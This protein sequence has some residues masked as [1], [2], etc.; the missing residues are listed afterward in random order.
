MHEELLKTL[1]AVADVMLVS[2]LRDKRIGFPSNQDIRVFIPDIHLISNTRSRFFSK[3]ATDPRELQLL[4][5]IVTQLNAFKQRASQQQKQVVVYQL[6]DC[7]DLWREIDPDVPPNSPQFRD[8]MQKIRD[9]NASLVRALRDENLATRF[10][11]GNHDIDLCYWRDGFMAWERGFFIENKIAVL[12]GDVFDMVERFPDWLQKLAVYFFSPK[13]SDYDIG[14]DIRP[15]TTKLR[16]RDYKNYLQYQ[17]PTKIGELVDCQKDIPDKYNVIPDHEFLD[18]ARQMCAKA[19]QQYGMQLHTV[20]IGH[21]HQARIVI[22]E[23]RNGELFTL[24][25]CGAWIENHWERGKAKPNAQI[26]ALSGNEVRI[27]QVKAPE[28]NLT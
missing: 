27:Y 3:Y 4:C 9:D 2:S 5:A 13:A 20:I 7:F 23:E 24:V 6:G 18:K 21:T 26:A 16:R 25:D 15:C 14:K 1:Q 19:N 22:H 12:H 17:D 10:L 8:K 11:F 28:G